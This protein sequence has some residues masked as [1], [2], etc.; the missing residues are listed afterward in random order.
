ML[1]SGEEDKQVHYYQSIEF[2]LALRR[3]QKPNILVLYEGERHNI[4]NKNHQ[5][6]LTHRVQQW[7]DYYLK[8]GKQPEWF[9]KDKY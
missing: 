5:I 1:W 7:W 2:H 8:K 4:R 3:L 9:T 6:D